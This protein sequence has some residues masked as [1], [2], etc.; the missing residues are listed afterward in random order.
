MKKDRASGRLFCYFLIMMFILILSGCSGGGGSDTPS[1]QSGDAESPSI[2]VS[3]SSSNITQASFTLSWAASTDNVGV[4]GYEIYQG[5]SLKGTS[6]STS[7]AVTGLAEGATYVM[8]VLARDAAGNR[9]D[10]S[11]TLSVTTGTGTDLKGWQL[12]ET[13][14]GLKG[15]YS[16]LTQVVV[17]D[18]GKYEYG[19]LSV[20]ANVTI[21]NKIIPYQL[22]ISAGGITIKNCLIQA[23]AVGNGMPMVGGMNAIIQDCEIDGSLLPDASVAIGAVAISMGDGQV[24]RCNIHSTSSGIQMYGFSGNIIA[25]G[26]YIHGLRYVAPAHIDGLTIRRAQGTGCIVQNNR[27]ITDVVCTGALFIQPNNPVNHVLVQGNLLEG[28]GYNLG[29]EQN[30]GGF[31]SDM[32]CINNRF[33]SYAANGANAWGTHYQESPGWAVWSENYIYDAK[34]IDG[35]G[36]LLNQ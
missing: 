34:G 36:T 21:Q 29:L 30:S 22:D 15:D 11:A 28:S 17:G 9:S 4:T 33:N 35:K 25:Q 3:L 1:T 13:N 14:T 2:P 23:T 7:F 8:S 32:S 24:L 10:T 16:S 6:V 26:N 18:V 5:G 27:I 12:N 20:N 19:T 31:G